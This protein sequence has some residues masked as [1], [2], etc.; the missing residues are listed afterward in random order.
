MENLFDGQ[1]TFRQ[2]LFMG[3]AHDEFQFLAVHLDAVGPVVRSYQFS[4]VL[5]LLRDPRQ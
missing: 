4:A 3:V 2:A 5:E 1:P